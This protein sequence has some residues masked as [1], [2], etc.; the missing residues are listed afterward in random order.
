MNPTRSSISR[1]LRQLCAL[2]MPGSPLRGRFSRGELQRLIEP[3]RA[4]L[5]V[6]VLG[7][8]DRMLARGRASIAAVRDGVCSACHLRLPGAHLASLKHSQ[9]IELC[10]NC[11]AFIYLAAPAPAPQPAPAP[12]GR[13]KAAKPVAR[14]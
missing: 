2:E 14:A 1:N 10:D 6:S 9:D 7:H 12:A 11:G 4:S 8:H 13:R 5:P 3:L